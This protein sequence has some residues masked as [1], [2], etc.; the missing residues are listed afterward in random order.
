[1]LDYIGKVVKKEFTFY[2]HNAETEQKWVPILNTDED[3]W[4]AEDPILASIKFQ[5]NCIWIEFS[6]KFDI[7]QDLPI[8]DDCGK[9]RG[10]EYK[11]LNLGEKERFTIRF[12]TKEEAE[13]LLDEI[14][15]TK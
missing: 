15:K 4:F 13:K 10:M 11:K 5:Q 9:T 3:G 8:V 2:S 6:G 12:K 7:Y 14:F 1:M